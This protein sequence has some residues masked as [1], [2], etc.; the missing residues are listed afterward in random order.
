MS[1]ASGPADA[2]HS[3]VFS[4]P[5]LDRLFD[6]HQV[7]DAGRALVR[8]VRSSPP[9][10]SVRSGPGHL[11]GVHPSRKMGCT[12]QYESLVE[13]SYVMECEYRSESARVV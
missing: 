10:R 7:N 9:S 13:L 2:P 4:D 12:H 8:E 1:R 5:E 3:F 11:T 6:E